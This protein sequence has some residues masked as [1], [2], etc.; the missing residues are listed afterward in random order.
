MV[1]VGSQL[2]ALY[3][4]VDGS[5]RFSENHWYVSFEAPKQ[6]RPTSSRAPSARQTKAFPT[7]REAK[8]FA[9]AKLSEGMNVTAGTLNPHLPT[10]RIILA[11]EIEQWISET[12]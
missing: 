6:W 7:E 8:Q 3:L 2:I 12:E 4:A 11:S 1:G 5:M 10:R 9:K